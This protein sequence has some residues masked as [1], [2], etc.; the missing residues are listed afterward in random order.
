MIE[1]TIMQ[2]EFPYSNPTDLEFSTYQF[3]NVLDNR[4]CYIRN[5]LGTLVIHSKVRFTFY[6]VIKHFLV[7]LLLYTK[8]KLQ[9]PN[10]RH[11]LSVYRPCCVDGLTGTVAETPSIPAAF[12]G[13]GETVEHRL[14]RPAPE[15]V[16]GSLLPTDIPR[17]LVELVAAIADG[18]TT[19]VQLRFLPSFS[20]GES[21]SESSNMRSVPRTGLR[22]EVVMEESFL[23][24][25]RRRGLSGESAQ[26][27]AALEGREGRGLSLP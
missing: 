21:S 3:Q 13:I 11:T 7:T 8:N 26:D 16:T 20:A 25:G 2:T 14:M 10:E 17:L 1:C 24:P 12:S 22:H 23:G 15:V 9:K 18:A 6:L 27:E 19:C 4:Y 5:T